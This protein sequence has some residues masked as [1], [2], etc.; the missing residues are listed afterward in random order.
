MHEVEEQQ[1]VASGR[2]YRH[3]ECSAGRN[4]R[5]TIQEGPQACFTRKN[6]YV[7]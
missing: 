2:P 3:R 7:G 6:W 4:L 5:V 1:S